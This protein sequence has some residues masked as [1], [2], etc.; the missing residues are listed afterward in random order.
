MTTSI[1]KLR[2]AQTRTGSL[3]CVGLEP[4]PEY[5]PKGMPCNLEGYEEALRR[6]IQATEGLVCAYKFNVAFFESLGWEG[7]ELL[8]CIRD[9]IP[10]DVLLIADAKRGDIGSTAKHY[11]RAL[12]DQLGADAVTLN[13]LMGF[14]SAEPFLAYETKLNFF[15]VLTS[16]PGAA[17]FLLPD[18]LYKKIGRK[19]V[20][21][22]QQHNCGFVV[23]ATWPERVG[24]LRA[25]APNVPFLVPG[26]GAQGGEIGRTLEAG[27]LASGT[28]GGLI[29]HVT[30]GILP[31]DE[32]TG[33]IVTIIRNKTEKWR[34]QIR[35]EIDK[36]GV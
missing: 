19:V 25:I 5:Q 16:N 6:I 3:L 15:L 21:W 14:D 33:D 7:A 8:Y 10:D 31:R 36:R 17:D 23:G 28:P 20:D 32:D 35:A 18:G 22:D 29:F 34:D 13:P 9:L 24:E 1:Q 2:D 11:A 4:C 12:Y 30:R 26:V 27:S